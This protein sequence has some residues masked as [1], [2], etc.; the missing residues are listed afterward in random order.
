MAADR[1]RSELASFVHV[2]LGRHARTMVLASEFSDP[3]P[4]PLLLALKATC[5]RRMIQELPPDPT[6]TLRQLD[7]RSLHQ[8]YAGWRGRVPPAR[9]RR[10]HISSDLLDNDDRLTYSDGLKAALDDIAHG[11]DLRPRASTAVG[12]AYT[13]STPP[14]LARG[15]SSQRHVDRL[16]ADWGL[17]HLHLG[18]TPHPKRPEFV[19]RTRHVLFVAFKPDD[20]YLVDIAEHESDGANWSALKLLEIVVRNWPDAGILVASTFAERL[21]NG[22]WSDED[23]RALRRAG[24]S[25]GSVEIDGNVWSAGGQ[26]VTGEPMHVARHCMGVSWQLSGYE[27]TELRV[28]DE[29]AAMAEKHEVPNEWRAVT[30]R[31]EYG[32][33]SNGVFVRYGSLLP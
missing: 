19:S 32:F 31:D 30:H 24:V 11:H 8:V 33:I 18:T 16:L 22:N 14:L 7:F 5:V 28:R 15:R 12:H 6:A 23:R 1:R 27:P 2:R 21:T 29:L 20:A 3:H 17:H 9:P 25:T 13:P 4:G 26:T 10:V